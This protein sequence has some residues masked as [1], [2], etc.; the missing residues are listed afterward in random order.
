MQCVASFM[1]S[2]YCRCR[3]VDTHT[4]L[5]TLVYTQCARPPNKT[6]LASYFGLH[7]YTVYVSQPIKILLALSNDEHKKI[8]GQNEPLADQPNQLAHA[9]KLFCH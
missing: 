5:V 3:D 8:Q 4:F 9:L 7:V 2:R 6:G 1:V